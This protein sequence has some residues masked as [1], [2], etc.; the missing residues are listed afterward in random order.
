MVARRIARWIFTTLV[1]DITSTQPLGP[2]AR[3]WATRKL[4]AALVISALLMW[5]EWVE[6]HPPEIALIVLHFLFVLAIIG[7]LSCVA[8]WFN[9]SS[10]KSPSR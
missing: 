1:W 2:W 5:R 7:L 6:H 10:D 3:L 4:L 9:R 8:Q